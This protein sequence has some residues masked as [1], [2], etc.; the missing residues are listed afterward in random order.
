MLDPEIVWQI[1]GHNLIAGR[2]QGVEDVIGYMQ[3]RAGSP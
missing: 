3:R 2:Y 1:P